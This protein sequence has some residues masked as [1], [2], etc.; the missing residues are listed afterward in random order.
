MEKSYEIPNLQRFRQFEVEM[1]LKVKSLMEEGSSG[2]RNSGQEGCQNGVLV[3]QAS[4][5][6]FEGGNFAKITL[7]NYPVNIEKN[8]NGHFRGLHIVILNPEN[9]EI[10]SAKVFDTYK[11]S[12]EFDTFSVTRIPEE[13]IVIAACKDECAT[14]LSE[15]GRQWFEDM[16]SKV[17]ASLEYR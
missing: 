12:N 2:S 7:N 16:G 17:I 6:G 5:G 1:G 4:S 8:E 9:G 15:A 13:Y 3:V 14:N 11:C 10:H